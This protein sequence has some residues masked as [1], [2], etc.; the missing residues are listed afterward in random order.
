[1]IKVIQKARWNILIAYIVITS[2]IAGFSIYE[3]IRFEDQCLVAV[4]V[5][6][7]L[8]IKGDT[9]TLLLKDG[10]IYDTTHQ[11]INNTDDYAVCLKRAFI[12]YDVTGD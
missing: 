6:K 5:E 1:M 12:Y 9:T 10:R 4:N 8:S 7:I 3:F 2:F 11:N